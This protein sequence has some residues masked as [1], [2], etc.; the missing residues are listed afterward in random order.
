MYTEYMKK[1]FHSIVPPKNFVGVQ[2]I[3]N[4]NFITIRLN[5]KHFANLSYDEKV[6]AIQYV[7]KVKKALEDAGAV[8]LVVR[9]T[10]E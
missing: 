1:A 3:D 2:L 4:E 5:E 10:V 7:F 9:N 6:E 8:V